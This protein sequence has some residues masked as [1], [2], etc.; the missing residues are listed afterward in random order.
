MTK[1]I[2]EQYELPDRVMPLVMLAMGY[3]AEDPSVRPRNPMDFHLFEGEY[4]RFSDDAV[5]EAMEEMDS[6][7]L[8]QDYYRKA[9][10]MIPLPEG[11]KEKYDFDSY[12][13][14]EHI[15]RKLGLW[16]EDPEELLKNLELCAFNICRDR[17]G[18]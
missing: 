10:Y 8:R 5:S 9:N 7:Y 16:G 17:A 4:T 13:W 6:G 12:S 2:R 1:K 3:P 18:K 15:S 14:T 11:M